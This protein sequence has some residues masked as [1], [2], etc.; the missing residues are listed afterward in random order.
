VVC[1]PEARVVYHRDTARSMMDDIGFVKT[2]AVVRMR[3]TR[4]FLRTAVVRQRWD[5]V[6]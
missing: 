3:A 5:M 1:R 2:S 6:G 4:I